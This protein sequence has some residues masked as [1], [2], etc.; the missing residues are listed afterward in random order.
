MRHKNATFQ[1]HHHRVRTDST[2]CIGGKNANRSKFTTKAEVK[3]KRWSRWIKKNLVLSAPPTLQ[4]S[5]FEPKLPVFASRTL[6]LLGHNWGP[7][8]HRRLSEAELNVSYS[9]WDHMVPLLF[10]EG[11]TLERAS[12]KAWNSGS[13]LFTCSSLIKLICLQGEPGCERVV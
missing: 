6:F 11:G 5:C 7:L 4:A 10:K 9:E 2:C 8:N 1:S 3:V 13:N 12:P